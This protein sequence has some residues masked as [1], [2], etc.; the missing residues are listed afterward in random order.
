[1]IKE[2]KNCGKTFNSSLRHRLYCSTMCKFEQQRYQSKRKKKG[3][4]N[5]L[6]IQNINRKAIELGMTYGEYVSKFG[7]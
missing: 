2:C 7:L 5:L 6:T 4:S 3:K 1:M